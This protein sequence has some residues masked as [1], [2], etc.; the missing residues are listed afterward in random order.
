MVN[1]PK[2]LLWSS[3]HGPFHRAGQGAAALTVLIYRPEA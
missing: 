2:G 3:A 1:F